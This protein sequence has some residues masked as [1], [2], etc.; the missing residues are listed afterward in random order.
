MADARTV[1][2]KLRKLLRVVDFDVETQRSITAQLERELNT[3]LSQ[4]KPLIKVCHF[5]AACGQVDA[6][7]SLPALHLHGWPNHT[8]PPLS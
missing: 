1:K 7:L 5:L 2:Q 6:P 4:H 8:Q 3:S